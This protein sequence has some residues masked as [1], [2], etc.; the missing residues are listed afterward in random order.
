MSEASPTI[1]P[2]QAPRI[3]TSPTPT[4]SNVLRRV[5]RFMV[6]KTDVVEPQIAECA[7]V[8]SPNQTERMAGHESKK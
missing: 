2:M 1:R 3:D 4:R 5:S 7:S 6:Y 8:N